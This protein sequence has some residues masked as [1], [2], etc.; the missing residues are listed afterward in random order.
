MTITPLRLTACARCHNDLAG[1][2][3][4]ARNTNDYDDNLFGFTI[5]ESGGQ[6]KWFLLA[7]SK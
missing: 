6:V 2:P 7:K 3:P 4:E 5:Y 1:D